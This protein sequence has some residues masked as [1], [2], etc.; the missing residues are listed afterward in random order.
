MTQS[1]TETSL[2]KAAKIAGLFFLLNLIIPLLNWTFVLSGFTAEGALEASRN[3]LANETLFRFGITMELLLAAG[4]IVLG[5]ALYQILKGVSSSLALLALLLKLAEATLMAVTV[6][7]PLAA[8]QLI[9]GDPGNTVLSPEQLQLPLGTVVNAHTAITAVPMVFLGL[10]MMVFC[11][12]FVRSKYIPGILAGFGILAFALIFIH[13]LLSIL[14]PDYARLPVYQV[15]FWTPSGVFEVVTGVWLLT[16]GLKT[17][18]TIN[19]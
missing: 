16:K 14:A 7:I 12:L 4:L 17:R 1:T 5:L 15:I 11:Y 6:I 13:A 8:L 18:Q 3:I 2:R 9:H 10:D 19:N